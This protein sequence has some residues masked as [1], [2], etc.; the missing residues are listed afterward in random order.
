MLGLNSHFVAA[1]PTLVSRSIG[2]G[3]A[4]NPR[5]RSMGDEPI[6]WQRER[7]I[8]VGDNQASRIAP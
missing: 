7:V 8:R 6:S 5:S 4:M 1:R 2:T 3:C